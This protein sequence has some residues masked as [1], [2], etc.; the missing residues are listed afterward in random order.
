MRCLILLLSFLLCFIVVQ[1]QYAEYFLNS[2]PGLGNATPL[3]ANNGNNFSAQINTRTLYEGFHK[4]YI[5]AKDNNGTWSM[6]MI[7]SFY[8]SNFQN[9]T[10]IDYV[11]FF[12]NNDPGLGNALPIEID[13][14]NRCNTTISTNNVSNGFHKL[15]IRVKDNNGTW[16]IPKIQSFYKYIIK[17]ADSTLYS[18]YFFDNDPG[19][20]NGV[21]V[22]GNSFT[23]NLNNLSIGKHKLYVRSI[24]NTET[25]SFP[26][27]KEFCKAPSPQFTAST[28]EICNG[29]EVEFIDQT[30][31]KNE[32][33]I[34]QWDLDNDGIIDSNQDGNT[35][36]IY[37]EWGEYQA[38]LILSQP[39]GCADTLIQNI[40]VHDIPE[41]I[42]ITGSEQ[43]CKGDKDVTYYANTTGFPDSIHWEVSPRQSYITIKCD[44][45]SLKIN[46]NNKFTGSAQI[47]A[48]GIN[49][50]GEGVFSLPKT[51]FIN[52]YPTVNFSYQNL[53]KSKVSFTNNSVGYDNLRWDFG[54]GSSSSKVEPQHTYRSMGSY[55]VSLS[56]SYKGCTSNFS[57]LVYAFST[58]YIDLDF[59]SIDNLSVDAGSDHTIESGQSITLGGNQTA[60]GGIEPYSFTWSPDL[61]LSST[62]DPNPN[63]YPANSITYN[64]KV[65]D[66][67][68]CI[69]SDDVYIETGSTSK[70][71]TASVTFNVYPNPCT[72]YITIK[73]DIL[74]EN[75]KILLHNAIGQCV[76]SYNIFQNTN[77]Y[78][79]NLSNIEPGYYVLSVQNGILFK[80]I[81]LTII[82][83]K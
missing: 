56:T 16:C 83:D 35:K 26:I 73:S 66:S 18:E 81:P 43:L 41:V 53:Y 17:R 5:R 70:S 37:A 52:D 64:V 19:I 28:N 71:I 20:N 8:K 14:H 54:D 29:E 13:S 3:L 75:T 32:N 36:F 50:C 4:L 69:L 65:V 59:H 22:Y 39:D 1:A 27:I 33:T 2:D 78:R 38:M 44:T 45:E 34:Y 74:I 40:K 62:N 9:A 60:E 61:F 47:K 76:N 21:H 77:E 55:E 11:E 49:R 67:R 82:K 23:A 58:K 31:D 42:S 72:E 7:H 48:K 10:G 68:G 25:W 30:T 57:S 63:A 79:L 80:T 46:W 12:I 15:Y 24:D 51:V 6:P